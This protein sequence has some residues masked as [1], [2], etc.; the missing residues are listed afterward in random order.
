M[1]W[2]RRSAFDP[3]RSFRLI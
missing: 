1:K 2:P 3:K